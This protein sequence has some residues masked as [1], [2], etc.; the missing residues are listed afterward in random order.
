MSN[1]NLTQKLLKA[2]VG[3]CWRDGSTDQKNLTWNPQFLCRTFP[4]F[5]IWCGYA[6]L[7]LDHA[8]G[9]WEESQDI[10]VFQ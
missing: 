10:I 6:A 7:T 3:T 8:H 4:I 9:T 1:Q 5:N 2:V